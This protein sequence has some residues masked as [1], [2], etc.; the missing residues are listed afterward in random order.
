MAF[1]W[2]NMTLKIRRF[3]FWIKTTQIGLKKQ[4]Q[5]KPNQ[6]LLSKALYYNIFL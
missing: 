6:I 3:R 5:M 2:K 4:C 1:Y